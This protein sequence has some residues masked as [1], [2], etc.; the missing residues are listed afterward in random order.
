M[1]ALT[2]ASLAAI[3]A[4]LFLIVGVTTVSA[5]PGDIVFVT[6]TPCPADF[7]TIGSTFGNHLA[8]L[9]AAPRGGALWIR[10]S[11]GTLKNLTAAAGYGM[12]GFQGAQ[13]IAVRDPAVHWSG[14]KVLFSM[15]IGAPSQQYQLLQFHWQLYEITGLGKNETPV[16]TKVPKQ[17]AAYNNV[18]P[19]YGTDDRIIFMSDRPRN[20]AAHLYPQRDEY[21][22]AP[23]VTGL[24]SLNPSNGNLVI[25]DHS[26]SGDFHPIVDSAGRVVFTRWDHLQRDQQTDG[27]NPFN[28]FNYSD[29]SANATPLNS[30]LEVFPEARSASEV[31]PPANRHTFN[32]FFPWQMNEDGTEHETLG[33]IGRHE[34]HTYFDRSFNNDSNLREFSFS[35]SSR[36]NQNPIQNFFQI[37]EDPRNPGWFFGVDAPEFQTHAAGQIV[38]LFGP[39]DVDASSMRVVYIT[40][41]DTAHPT[42]TP[43]PN[44]SGLYRNPLPLTTGAI[45]ASHTAETRDDAN[46]GTTA[47]PLSRYDFRLKNLRT[48]GNYYVADTPLTAGIQATLSYWNPDTFVQYSGPLWELQPV[49]LVARTRPDRRSAHLPNPELSV[50]NDAG[51]DPL[52]MRRYLFENNLSLIV[53]RN[54]TTRDSADLQQPF[55]LRVPGTTTQTVVAP[56]KIYDATHFQMFQGDQIRGYGGTADPQRGR[57]VL[58]NHLHDG[59]FA[60]LA[61][62]GGPTGSVKVAD[63]GSVAAIVPARRAM[64]WQLTD[65]NGTPTVRERYWLSF[66]PGE[67]RVCTSCHGLTDV[68]Q[69]GRTQPQNPPKALKALL[70]QF[71]TNPPPSN[72]SGDPNDPDYP[73]SSLPQR[74][75][76]PARQYLAW[77]GFLS[78]VNILE[79]V[80]KGNVARNVSVGLYDNNGTSLNLVSIQVPA[81]G[82]RDLILNDMAGFRG[83]QYGLVTLDYEGNDFDGRVTYYHGVA[84]LPNRYDFAYTIPFNDPVTSVSLVPFNTYQPSQNPAEAAHQVANWLSI[85][86]LDP[87]FARSFTVY[88]H[89]EDGSI[90]F[91]Q[92]VTVGPFGRVDVEGGHVNPGA[93]RVGLNRIVPDTPG[94]LYFAQ[95]VRYGSNAPAGVAPTAYSFAFPLFAHAEGGTEQFVPISVGGGAKNWLELANYSNHEIFGSL[96]LYDGEG[97]LLSSPPVAIQLRPY[98]QFHLEAGAYLPVGGSGSARLIS[99][100]SGFSAYSMHYFPDAGGSIAALYG[101]PLQAFENPPLSGSYNLFLGMANWLKLVNPSSSPVTVTVNVFSNGSSTPRSFSLPAHGSRDL[102]LHD[103]SLFGT[104]PDTYDLVEVTGAPVI[105][106]VLRVQQIGAFFD[107]VFPTPL[108][109]S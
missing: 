53:M 99:S 107:F 24:W 43:S 32:Q 98:A 38:K 42:D 18:M 109:G 104:Q 26:P 36:F 39:A 105:G 41:P 46:Q 51:V 21:E 49:E 71:K 75:R 101:T 83:D 106:Q 55:N 97:H 108:R 47:N 89:A 72:P 10:Y 65:G 57:R 3:A 58:A 7:T 93:S 34:L 81:R 82:Q 76:A 35:P 59:L 11:D 94:S 8:S 60:N 88:R 103:Q 22:S 100:T 61:N 17:D 96:E 92:R 86:N 13:S 23:T 27:N 40:H 80:N 90:L 91:S 73:G 68:D 25:L 85:V 63:D 12:V 70:D 31:I 29:E 67:I 19:T 2:Q 5:A 54:V 16:I 87:E 20:A 48:S 102:P 79:L 66:Q 62:P 33:H 37:R 64:T 15:V 4:V 56:G 14:T 95:L 6:Q 77:N 45:V 84:G 28:G 74:P 69:A 44:H 1:R 9:D 30:R 52:D 78:M 50:F